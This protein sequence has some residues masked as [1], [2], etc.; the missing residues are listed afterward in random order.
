MSFNYFSNKKL[1]A[2][3]CPSLPLSKSNYLISEIG[4]RLIEDSSYRFFIHSINARVENYLSK[5][6]LQL[7]KS[8]DYDL[9]ISSFDFLITQNRDYLKIKKESFQ[10]VFFLNESSF[11]FNIPSESIAQ[12][13]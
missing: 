11:S 13:C 2:I 3:Y 9:H 5:T 7:Y 4:K 10:K 12:F 1:V 6:P 8:K